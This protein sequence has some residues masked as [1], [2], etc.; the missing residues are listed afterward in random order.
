MNTNTQTKDTKDLAFKVVT[1]VIWF[2]LAIMMAV[3]VYREMHH[4]IYQTLTL[5]SVYWNFLI[6]AISFITGTV[7]NWIYDGA[8]D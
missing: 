1:K 3:V 6:G 2:I 8:F 5:K 4:F 7:F